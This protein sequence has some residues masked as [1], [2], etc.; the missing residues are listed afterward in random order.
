[1]SPTLRF[2]EFFRHFSYDFLNFSD[3]SPTL[4]HMSDHQRFPK[5]YLKPFFGDLF[6]KPKRFRFARNA[7]YGVLYKHF[8]G[9]DELKAPI[10][11]SARVHVLTCSPGVGLREKSEKPGRRQWSEFFDAFLAKTSHIMMLLVHGSTIVCQLFV[12]FIESPHP[13]FVG[14]D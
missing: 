6:F 5:L 4:R 3:I 7:F 1:M 12:F 2:S 10:L 14:V 9:L 13:T 11:P 8:Y